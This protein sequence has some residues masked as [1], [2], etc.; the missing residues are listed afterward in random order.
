M[1]R[2]RWDEARERA[3]K[4]ANTDG[5]VALA[6]KIQQFQ[7]RDIRPKAASEIEDIG[8]ASR[9]LGHSKEAM[10]KKVYRRVGE[11]VKPTR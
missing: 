10:T 2:N 4:K 8:H 3:T 11:I 1:L 5:D 7:F 9:L 6:E